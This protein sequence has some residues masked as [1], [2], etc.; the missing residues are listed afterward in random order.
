MGQGI[1][2]VDDTE[3]I[4]QLIRINFE[5]EGFEVLSAS[6]GIEGLKRARTDRPDLVLSDIMMPRLDGLQLLSELRA[7]PATASLPVVL[8]SAKAQNAEVEQ[9]LALGASDYVTKPFDPLEL[10]DRVNAVLA[11]PRS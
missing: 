11:N 2:V 8:L 6:D 4:R 1:L 3:S 10:I 5:I 7:D 9:G